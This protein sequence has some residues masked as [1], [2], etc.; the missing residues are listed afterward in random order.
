[1][2]MDL[3][4]AMETLGLLQPDVMDQCTE[5]GER[6]GLLTY[7]SGGLRGQIGGP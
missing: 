4:G 7:V 5:V 1:M 3:G 2:R 6:R